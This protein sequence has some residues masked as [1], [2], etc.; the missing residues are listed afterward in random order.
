MKKIRVSVPLAALAVLIVFGFFSC[1]ADKKD[2]KV[3]L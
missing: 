1:A 3:V 2:E